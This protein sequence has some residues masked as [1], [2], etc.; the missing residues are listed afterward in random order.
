MYDNQIGS[1]FLI[2][3][4]SMA[5]SMAIIPVMIRLAPRL[6]MV[7][8]PDERK[9]HTTPIPRVGG[10]GIVIGALIPMFIWLPMND[11]VVSF[12]FG[13]IVLLVFGIWDDI[14][15]LG[16]YVKFIGQFISVIAVVYYGDL[17][18]AH[19]PFIG[20]DTI[21]EAIGKPFTV[22]AIVGVIN[23][24]NHSDGL[25]GLAG[26]ESLLSLGAMAYLAYLFD[27][28]IILVIAFSTIG[29]IFG[30]LRYNSY[31]AKVF[32]GDG[33][34]Q[35]LGFTLGFLVVHLTQIT[36]P[37]LSP[38][39]PL[40]I[41]GLPIADILAVFYLRAKSG[42]NLFRATKNHVH[43]RL[44]ELGFLHYESVIIIYSIQVLFVLSAVIFP[45]END[46]LLTCFY[47]SGIATIFTALTLCERTSYKCHATRS[48]E[49]LPTESGF[50][51]WMQKFLVVPGITLEAGVSIFLV[52]GALMSGTVP[53]DFGI[54]AVLL[55]CI[56][57]LLLVRKHGIMV[58]YR[59]IAFVTA[60]F[61]VYLLSSYPPVW[62]LEQSM[63]IYLFFALIMIATFLTARTL[64]ADSFQITPLD[65]LVIIFAVAIALI[66]EAGPDTHSMVMMA[67][68]MIVLFYACEMIIQTVNNVYN[69]FTGS[70]TAALIII[71]LRAF[72]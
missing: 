39:L 43:H 27:G 6:G 3:I 51:N 40:L 36:N 15:E 25:D 63:I 50:P 70:L 9:V 46:Y 66:P 10:I 35:F 19:F 68:Q 61:A 26:G 72:L 8:K 42:V 69:R 38:A 55:L 62:L 48:S 37:V 32:M 18:V 56:M 31:P 58:P 59:L 1:Y 17:W 14:V 67:L 44:L 13:S 24:I 53:D 45:Y 20:I 11:L 49:N 16:H 41:L 2:A 28:D 54:A 60:G 7:D 65:Y 29:G 33:G 52:G 30:F 22:I 5:V 71:S 57:L 12:L 21:P 34:S 4:L 23:A 47:L 64:Q